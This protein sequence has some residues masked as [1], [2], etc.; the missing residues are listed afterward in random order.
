MNGYLEMENGNANMDVVVS[1]G[2]NPN[3]SM[4]FRVVKPIY[5]QEL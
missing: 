5:F 2:S 3:S 4:I 1:I